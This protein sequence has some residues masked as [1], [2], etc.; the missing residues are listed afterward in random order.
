MKSRQQSG[1][2]TGLIWIN[3]RSR[4]SADRYLVVRRFKTKAG[5]KECLM[6]YDEGM[7]YGDVDFFVHC[8]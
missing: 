2:A 6:S 3:A 5:K 8:Y 1:A 7:P 4:S